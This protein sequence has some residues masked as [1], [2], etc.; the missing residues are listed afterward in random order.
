MTDSLKKMLKSVDWSKL[1][2]SGDTRNALVGSALGGLM[3]GGASLM[4]DRDPEESK[5]APVGDALMGAL[6]GGA[7]GYG[8]PKGLAMFRDAGHMAPDD[9]QIR[10]GSSL[11]GNMATG[12]KWGAGA[13]AGLLA[14]KDTPAAFKAWRRL[15]HN[16]ADIAMRNKPFYDEM[17]S[18]LTRARQEA[19]AAGRDTRQIDWILGRFK[20]SQSSARHS[21]VKG[22]VRT[23]LD[24]RTVVDVIREMPRES[25]APAAA[26]TEA[27]GTLGK[28]VKA[29]SGKSG[30]F[31]HGSRYAEGPGRNLL[32][33]QRNYGPVMKLLRR[34]GKYGARGAAVGAGAVLAPR[35]LSALGS[36]LTKTDSAN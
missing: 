18:N 11:A 25:P 17:I 30:F 12:A 27:T 1:V 7:A 6:L 2:S 21:F 24:P 22:L 10:A 23:H 14:A 15:V 28:L 4:Q 20:A 29:L 31:T 33:M 19:A 35:V 32:G 3:L 5:A 36:L 16:N 8:I 26:A 34:Y 13:G 9:D